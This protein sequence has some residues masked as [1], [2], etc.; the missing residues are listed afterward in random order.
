MRYLISLVFAILALVEVGPLAAQDDPSKNVFEKLQIHGHLTQAYGASTGPTVLG[1][2]DD[3]TTDYR[4]VALQF[5]YDHDDRNAFVIQFNHQRL[6]SDT[7]F[8][9][10]VELDWAFY[11]RRI[12]DHTQVRVGR[13]LTPLGLLN[14]VRDVG[15][16]L[17]FYRVPETFYGEAS[18]SLET[19]D[20]LSVSHTFE[21]SSGS[22]ELIGYF[23]GWDSVDQ[24]PGGIAEGRIEEG[25]GLTAI[26]E[27]AVEGLRFGAGYNEHKAAGGLVPEGTRQ[28]RDFWWASAELDRDRYSFIVELFRRDRFVALDEGG[29]AQA[30]FWP[31]ERLGLHVQT[32]H[33]DLTRS[34]PIFQDLNPIDLVEDYAAGFSFLFGSHAMV[35]GE[36][37]WSMARNADGVGLFATDEEARFE[38]YVISLAVSF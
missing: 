28:P 16:V 19:I 13:I 30:S 3:G 8:Q 2:P 14:E 22:L 26:V 11:Q 34:E 17:P 32:E 20:G 24:G 5:R 35:K 4:T 1:I 15:T 38:Y 31:K 21:G 36:Y 9:D 10:D 29:Y 27:T 12:G 37:H 33:H 6:A 23:G 25:I 7:L 18:F